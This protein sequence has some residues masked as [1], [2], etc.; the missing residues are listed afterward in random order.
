MAKSVNNFAKKREEFYEKLGEKM[1]EKIRQ[2]GLAAWVKPWSLYTTI[3]SKG[4][5]HPDRLAYRYVWMKA[6]SPINQLLLEPG[7]YITFNE[8]RQLGGHIRKG[9]KASVAAYAKKF[10][11][12]ATAEEEQQL[13]DPS[14]HRGETV[15]MNG[16]KFTS[17]GDHWQHWF[18]R[19]VGFPVFRIEDT[20]GCRGLS[21]EEIEKLY[22]GDKTKAAE[23][24]EKQHAET[25]ERIEE[26]LRK[27]REQEGIK[28]ID[29]VSDSAFYTPSLKTITL[30]KMS[31][32]KDTDGYYS[33]KLHE[34]VH[35]TGN[36]LRHEEQVVI[37]RFGDMHYSREELV[38][39]M[40][41]VFL[42]ST[43]GRLTD[44]QAEQSAKYLEGWNTQAGHKGDLEKN[45]PVA[46]MQATKAANMILEE[47]GYIEKEETK[48]ENKCRALVPS[49]VP[50]FVIVNA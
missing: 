49:Y 1:M 31:Q 25:D 39:E 28:E 45:L 30:P 47:G 18:S 40:G 33:T 37:H 14:E 4:G 12:R 42:L 15:T 21:K 11:L 50:N 16:K 34:H 8:A 36:K 23:E 24:T 44:W 22:R 41:N 17:D 38:A 20:E 7:F 5:L 43:F 46:I 48:S 6:F 9:A 10:A 13:G 19:L 2:G 32:F 35:S 3:G 26:V 29:K 27:Y